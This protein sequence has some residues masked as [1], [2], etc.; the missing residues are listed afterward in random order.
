M[1]CRLSKVRDW[2]IRATHEAQ[3]HESNSFITLTYNDEKLPEDNS[4]DVRD[5]QLFAK[6]LRKALGPFRFLHCGEYGETNKRPHYHA[7]LFGQDFNADRIVFKENDQHLLWTSP[8]LEKIW[9]MG[10]ATIGPLNYDTAAYVARYALKKVGGPPKKDAYERVNP[11]TGEI[12]QV[13]P[14]YATMSRRP[15]LGTEWFNKYH[16][17]VYPDDFVII[18]GKKFRPPKHYDKLLEQKNPELMEQLKV[19]RQNVT[20]QKSVDETYERRNVRDTVIKA[21]LLQKQRQL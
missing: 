6:K 8:Q 15:G 1:S 21:K 14:E 9:G 10:F 20:K 17:D 3:M 18:Q 19:K 16:D 12:T 5:W 4:V 11:K 2:A 13:K 7:C